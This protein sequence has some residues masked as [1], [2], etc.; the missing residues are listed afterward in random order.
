MVEAD[1][2]IRDANELMSQVQKRE[3]LPLWLDGTPLEREQIEKL[4]PAQHISHS[5]ARGIFERGIQ[6]RTLLGRQLF[7]EIMSQVIADYKWLQLT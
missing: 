1:N 5:I 4:S 6:P 2:F 7:T 3:P